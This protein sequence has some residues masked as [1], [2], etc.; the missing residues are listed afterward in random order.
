[1]TELD[2]FLE[3]YRGVAGRFPVRG[4]LV[5]MPIRGAAPATRRLDHLHYRYGFPK[6]D[7]LDVRN[8]LA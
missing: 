7:F 6:F 5:L 4:N 8:P 3:V 1:L 2:G